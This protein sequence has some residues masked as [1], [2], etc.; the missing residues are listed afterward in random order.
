M[1]DSYGKGFG[2]DNLAFAVFLI[3][4]LLVFSSGGKYC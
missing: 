4:I 2:G 3:L 1:G